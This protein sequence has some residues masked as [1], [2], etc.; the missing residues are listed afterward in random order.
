MLWCLLPEQDILDSNP[1]FYE[2]WVQLSNLYR[3]WEQFEN[4]FYIIKVLGAFYLVSI[5]LKVK[6]LTGWVNVYP[7][8]DSQPNI[9]IEDLE[10]L[11]E[12][13]LQLIGASSAKYC[14]DKVEEIVARNKT[15][16]WS[17]SH[18][19]SMQAYKIQN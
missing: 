17:T 4:I 14:Q 9:P 5:P 8:T 19:M 18:I 10:N 15:Q 2:N 11:K 12:C 7:A 13:W 16:L 3:T 6:D 1:S